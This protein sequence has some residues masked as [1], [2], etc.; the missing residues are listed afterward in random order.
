MVNT[1]LKLSKALSYWT[2][3]FWATWGNNEVD[4]NALLRISWR[5]LHRALKKLMS[6][7]LSWAPRK[8]VMRL[9]WTANLEY[10]SFVQEVHA[11][12][13][14]VEKLAG[15]LGISKIE[16]AD[17]ATVLAA[18]VLAMFDDRRIRPRKGLGFGNIRS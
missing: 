15:A 10:E 4:K 5:S 13:G 11:F 16:D 3:K 1:T 14:I 8:T 9:F 6:C 12:T 7:W 17:T 2:G 18:S